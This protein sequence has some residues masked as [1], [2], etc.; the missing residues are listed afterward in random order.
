MNRRW[1]FAAATVGIAAVMGFAANHSRSMAASTP[2]PRA[3]IP[4]ATPA[5][6]P[7]PATITVSGQELA[8]LQLHIG[9]AESEPLIRTV[10]AT[11]TIGYNELRLARITPT[12][13]GRIEALDVVVGDEVKAGQRLAVLDNFEL[14]TVRSKVASAQA[15]VAQARAQLATA[16]AALV[17]ATNLV[18]TGG[19]AQSELDARRA[20]TAVWKPN[21]AH[22]GHGCKAQLRN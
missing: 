20:M 4:D 19:M 9:K 13:R 3:A 2:T 11:G 16:Q 8:N 14:S 5:D 7:L 17:R 10:M 6:P 1:L 22:K 12:A 21:F 15:A 18:R